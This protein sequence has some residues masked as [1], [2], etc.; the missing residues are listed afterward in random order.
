MLIKKYIQL[1]QIVLLAV[2]VSCY[3]WS[4]GFSEGHFGTSFRVCDSI[5][6]L[7]QNALLCVFYFC[8]AL[9]FSAKFGKRTPEAK[10]TKASGA[11]CFGN[12]WENAYARILSNYC[13]LISNTISIQQ[14][15]RNVHI[16]IQPYHN[17]M[18]YLY[19]FEYLNILQ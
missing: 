10:D 7:P 1:R 11:F 18:F 6:A 9:T 12:R 17:A 19:R 15:R 13:V 14:F 8:Y 3:L 2:K 16:S 5:T 4:S